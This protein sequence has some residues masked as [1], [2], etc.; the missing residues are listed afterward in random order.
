MLKGLSPELEVME[1]RLPEAGVVTSTLVSGFVDDIF[2][3]LVVC[4]G[5][6]SQA[7]ATM[8][9]ATAL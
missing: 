5:R 6:R 1:F 8:A 7:V 4:S 2:L 9:L 3:K